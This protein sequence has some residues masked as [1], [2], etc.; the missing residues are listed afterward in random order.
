MSRF[1]VTT[2]I[3]YLN[4]Q[5]H[6]GFAQEVLAADV[7]ARYHREIKGDETYF[8]TGTDE[9]GIKVFE[10]AQKANKE[11]KDFVDQLANQAQ[12]M[13]K[14]LN[15]SNDGFIRTTDPK[16]EAIVKEIWQKAL[17]AGY[18]YKK[19]YQGLYCHGCEGPLKKHDLIN[20][21][22]PIHPN[23]EPEDI[24]EENWFFKLSAFQEPLLD[25]YAKNADFI[26]PDSRFNEVKRFVEAGLEDI[27]ISR[28]KEKL[29]WGIEV[30]N[31]PSHVMYVWFDALINYL[32]PKN[33]WPADLHIVGKDIMRFHATLWPAMLMASGYEL[34]TKIFVH[35]FISVE[36]QKMSKSLGNVILPKDMIERFGTE[37]TRH[38][39][40]RE[41]PFQ[42]DSDFS[43]AK[44]TARFNADLANDLG[45]LVQRV[46]TM[47]KNYQLKL[48]NREIPSLDEVWQN[49]ESLQFDRAL[50]LI[51]QQIMKANQTIDQTKP[52]ELAK[53]G[54]TADLEKI[55]ADLH[56]TL[57]WVAEG[58]KP[59]L[60]E[61]SQRMQTQIKSLEFEPLFPRLG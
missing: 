55:L 33:R 44:M 9:H 30:P 3:L 29:S 60:P 36:G 52:W 43:W 22:C 19:Q 49:L 25:F 12:D 46:L 34:P 24:K 4:A 28:P 1:Y 48:P 35:G 38:L 40:L 8:L 7:I 2:S 61:T 32:W 45:N 47:T 57:S 10:A 14:M 18:I 51:W 39:L 54:K 13:L 58:L 41:L 56:Q 23:L 53:Q 27:S 42:K 21:R 16:H 15:I 26:Q 59:F 6:I 37:G 11:P 31:D 50:G 20:G 17:Q 5:P